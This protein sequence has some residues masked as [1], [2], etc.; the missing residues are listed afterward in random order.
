MV[1]NRNDPGLSTV[2]DICGVL[3]I[4]VTELIGEG[5]ARKSRP[6]AQIAPWDVNEF[7]EM[8]INT[9]AQRARQIVSD[10]GVNPT[11]DD[12]I[13]WWHEHGGRLEDYD[14][15]RDKVDLFAPPSGEA[16]MPV[17][18]RLGSDSLVA[19][20]FSLYDEDHLRNLLP[21]LDNGRAQ[22]IATAHKE[23]L[24]GRPILSVE[25]M[26]VQL[27]EKGQSIRAKYKR[28]LLPVHNPRGDA[29]VLNYSQLIA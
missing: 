21:R 6:V 5:P 29:F 19:R 3:G 24:S 27:P 18:F 16:S 13:E 11:I 23:A 26:D 10:H 4:E 25:E 9:A 8:L 2:I 17:P 15:L 1:R 12:V 7:A 28:L 22:K 20:K 14:R